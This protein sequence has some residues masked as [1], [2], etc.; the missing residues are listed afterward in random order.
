MRSSPPFCVNSRSSSIK[1]RKPLHLMNET[2]MSMRSE[3]AISFLSSV[4]ICGSCTAP[5]KRLLRAMDVSGRSRSAAV[6]QA[7]SQGSRSL[8]SAR[9]CSA[10]RP[11]PSAAKSASCVVSCYEVD[12]L[13]DDLCVEIWRQ[14]IE[15]PFVVYRKYITHSAIS[16]VALRGNHVSCRRFISH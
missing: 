16:Q 10:R 8:K 9:S 6:L 11:T 15:P 2:S 7:A 3:E 5:V 1:S 13:V 14:H 12:D 4:Y